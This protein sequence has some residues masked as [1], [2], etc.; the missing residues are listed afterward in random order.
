MQIGI[1][2]SQ[3]NRKISDRLLKGALKALHEEGVNKIN[4]GVFEVP[5]AFEIP[6][7][8]QK[9]ADYK[10]FD[11]IIA[12]GC[13]LKGET[14]H[15]KAVCEGVTYGIQ[16]VSIENRLPVMFGV[17][18]CDGQ[19]LA[20]SRSAENAKNKGYECGKGLIGILQNK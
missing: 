15:Y 4:I 18:M 19:D 14:D 10:K 2:V 13:V 6:F 17:L 1:I 7:M 8:A 12:L 11:G 3:F 20:L 9:L 5:G 16:K